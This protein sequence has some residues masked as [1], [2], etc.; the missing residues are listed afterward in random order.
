VSRDNAPALVP[1]IRGAI[2]SNGNLSI[3]LSNVGRLAA[4]PK[5]VW[6]FNANCD[7]TIIYNDLYHHVL[8]TLITALIACYFSFS[9]VPYGDILILDNF[10]VKNK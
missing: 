9:V 3:S 4:H 7:R 2:S 10:K 5:F 1:P 8:V 6:V